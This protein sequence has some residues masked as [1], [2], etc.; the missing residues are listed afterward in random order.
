MRGL[1][2]LAGLLIGLKLAGFILWDWGWILA[3][4]YLYW[5]LRVLRGRR[6]G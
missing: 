3:P 1:A 2:T 4:V 6:N 5:L